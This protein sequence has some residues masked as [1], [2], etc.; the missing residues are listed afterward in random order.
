VSLTIFGGSGFV[1][2]EYKRQFYHHAVGN[3][4]AFNKRDDYS[5]FSK[6]ILYLLSTV[7]NYHIFDAPLLDVETNLIILV[8]V[9][10]S[11]RKYQEESGQK[12]VFNFASSWSV[13]GDQKELPVA[14]NAI[15][16][17]K[18]WYIITKRCAEQLL[19]EY[20]TTFHL[21]YKILRFANVIGS[22]DK[23]ASEKKN[24]LQHLVNKLAKNEDVEIFGDGSFLRDFIHVSDCV[25]AVQLVMDK[26][27]SNEIYNVG[28][29]RTWYYKDILLYAKQNLGSTGRILHVEPSEFQANVPVQNFYMDNTKI[30]RLGYY[31][32]YTGEQLFNTLLPTGKVEY[33]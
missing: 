31:P 19:I 11:W 18:G 13:Y 9:L 16:N 4:Y 25:A 5:V 20:C 22:H 10:E 2:S 17:P 30:R 28:N 14:E 3:I 27:K 12:G 15:C 33:E 6:D 32:R 23:K 1:G 24:V 29:G 26:G 21:N 7:H 8:K